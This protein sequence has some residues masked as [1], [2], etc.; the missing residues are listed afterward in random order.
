MLFAVCNV[1]YHLVAQRLKISFARYPRFAS[2]VLH[3]RSV[4]RIGMISIVSRH[5]QK[6]NRAYRIAR[7]QNL[8]INKL[9]SF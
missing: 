9:W 8:L 3:R 1:T 2:S 7:F 6:S 4:Y 5:A